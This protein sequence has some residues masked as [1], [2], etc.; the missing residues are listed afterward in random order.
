MKPARITV[1]VGAATLACDLYGPDDGDLVMCVHGF[2]DC[3][4][5]FRHQVDALAERGFRVATP[6]LRGYAPSSLARDKRYDVAALAADLCALAMR[7]STRPVRLVGHDWGAI[8]SYAA[9][10]FAPHLFSHLC[11]IAVPHL[12]VAS[13]RFATAAQLKR[14]WYMAFFQLPF[15]PERKVA[16][17]NMAF[18]DRLWRD[19]SPGFS[20]PVE[21]LEA[22][23]AA[24]APP[25]HLRAA[26]AYYR[27]LTS[28]GALTGESRKLLFQRTELPSIYLHGVDDG[29]IGVE[30]AR[31][32][33]PAYGPRFSAHLIEGAGHF[34]HQEQPRLF[35]AILLDFLSATPS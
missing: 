27:A 6:T 3:A 33:E 18:I 7:L 24:L 10:A 17:S 23:K 13:A 9:V 26:L 14:S 5:S 31:S 8:A 34:V 19:W 32:L 12:R 16:Q 25:D 35:N 2:P 29:C 22:I 30:L 1:D 15:I 20:P 11:T 21:E 4:R 28:F